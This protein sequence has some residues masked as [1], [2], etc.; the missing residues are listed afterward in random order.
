[1]GGDSFNPFSTFF[2][3]MNVPSAILCGTGVIAFITGLYQ[4]NGT[5]VLV[6]L[7]L[8]SVGMACHYAPRIRRGRLMSGW[9][10]TAVAAF[11]I[12]IS[13]SGL[14]GYFLFSRLSTGEILVKGN[15]LPS[16][17][18]VNIRANGDSAR[19]SS[20][21]P[22]NVK[23]RVPPGEFIVT[24]LSGQTLYP[25]IF[26]LAG[27][28]Y[29]SGT[30]T[31]RIEARKLTEVAAYSVANLVPPAFQAAYKSY[32][33]ELGYPRDEIVD[34]AR[35]VGTVVHAIFE[36]G[37]I[38]WLSSSGRFY[39]ITGKTWS[40]YQPAER[41]VARWQFEQAEVNKR[42]S[43][44]PGKNAPRGGTFILWEKS[45]KDAFGWLTAECIYDRS[46]YWQQFDGGELI[47][48]V[49]SGAGTRGANMLVL[50][51]S[52]QIPD[53][54]VRVIADSVPTC[55]RD[56]PNEAAPSTRYKVPELLR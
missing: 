11:L 34:P 44:P 18:C 17:V 47:G 54:V 53:E 50:K 6:G 42:A 26:R 13:L 24:I 41:V 35:Q 5:I 19:F 32:T 28:R 39:V 15:D 52:P 49:M 8:G 30:T 20:V 40:D 55:G 27:G 31:V 23:G 43:A 4:G 16:N 46:V 10:R 33:A 36:R 25:A 45:Y 48:A 38:L 9:N 12:C 7:I 22:L 3:Y 21:I 29:I 51:G 1:M 14:F 37:E 2:R 56:F